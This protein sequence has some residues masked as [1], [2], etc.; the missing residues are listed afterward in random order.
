[1]KKWNFCGL[2]LALLVACTNP[3]KEAQKLLDAFDGKLASI[4][5][6][7]TLTAYELHLKLEE[8][9]IFL[10]KAHEETRSKLEKE[11]QRELFDKAFNLDKV[12]VYSTLLEALTEKSLKSLDALKKDWWVNAET[13]DY[14]T[15]F[16]LDD[17]RLFFLNL[18]NK[19]TYE[20]VNGRIIFSEKSGI[21]PLFFEVHEDSLLI[22]KADG[23]EIKYERFSG[24][25]NIIQG[26]WWYG[27]DGVRFNFYKGNKF[28]VRAFYV[29]EVAS[30]TYKLN[31][32]SITFKSRG[33]SY[34]DDYYNDHTFNYVSANKLVRASYSLEAERETSKGPAA[35]NFL[36][37][38]NLKY[39]QKEGPRVKYSSP[40][41]TLEKSSMSE[42]KTD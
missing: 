24:I 39:S 20:I 5:N 28:S 40:L 32:K 42:N 17:Q 33:K 41:S 6:V 21:S 15:A 23:E 38:G 13:G 16:K 31:G 2:L 8:A 14:K 9:Y 10:L 36:F 18:S 26:Q 11:E 37:D 29:G 4:A 35:L 1:M 30:G 25:E 27:A 22:R 12:S 7:E 19:F 34:G 3:E